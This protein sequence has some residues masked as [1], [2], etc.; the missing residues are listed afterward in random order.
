MMIANMERSITDI[1]FSLGYSSPS[2]FTRKFTEI[3]GQSPAQ[4]RKMLK[5]L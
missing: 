2:F 5:S 1:A 3:K 4:F